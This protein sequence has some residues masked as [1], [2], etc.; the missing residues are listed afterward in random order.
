MMQENTW[1]RVRNQSLAIATRNAGFDLAV[2][3]D[4]SE[5]IQ[6]EVKKRAIKDIILEIREAF[7]SE[8]ELE[9][10]DLTQGIY[11]ISLAT[12]LTIQYQSKRS[13]V[14][15]IGIGNVV[16]RIENHFENSL[17]DFMQSLSGA[18][19]DFQ[20]ACPKLKWHTDYYKHIEFLMLEYFRNAA[21]TLPIL[22]NNAG[23]DR[24]INHDDDWWSKPL[25]AAGKTPRW[26][27]T[28]LP[29]SGFKRLD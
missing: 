18:N 1:Y 22:N 27:L 3:N 12:P 24:A 4:Y 8:T 6:K 14:I 29:K 25:K 7:E 15:Y 16:S 19:F 9:L 11:V 26:A 2:W 17:F 23:S 13:E 5:P 10:G 28:A 21:G 20:F